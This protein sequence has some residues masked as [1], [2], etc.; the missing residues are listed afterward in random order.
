MTTT[1][2]TSR[3]AALTDAL[4]GMLARWEKTANEQQAIRR[5]DSIG[6]A[7]GILGCIQ[8]L[9]ALLRAYPVEQHEAAPADVNQLLEAAALG[10]ERAGMLDCMRIVRGMKP[11]YPKQPAPASPLEGT[12]NGADERVANPIGYIRAD[13]LKELAAGNGAIISPK[14]GATDVPVFA[15][16]PRTEVAG[17]V[18]EGWK[19]MPPKMTPAMRMAFAEAAAEYMKRT[20]GNNPDVMYKAAFDA[21][22]QAPSA[23]AAA[24]PADER[25]DFP[26]YTE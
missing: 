2:D 11:G 6:V 14:C 3:A 17:A 5:V 23:D 24:A 10:L 13:D 9:R 21:A 19:L 8:G 26:R 1:T 22:P 20:G 12:G 15:R 16:A 18:P 25:T 7:G 4:Q